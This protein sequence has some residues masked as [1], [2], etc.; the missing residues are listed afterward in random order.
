MT[1]MV[2]FSHFLVYLAV[3]FLL[4]V[5]LNGLSYTYGSERKARLSDALNLEEGQ[6]EIQKCAWLWNKVPW[7]LC[8]LAASLLCLD[9]ISWCQVIASHSLASCTFFQNSVIAQEEKEIRS[10]DF[11]YLFR[12]GH[13]FFMVIT[14]CILFRF[15]W[16]W[17]SVSLSMHDTWYFYLPDSSVPALKAAM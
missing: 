13:L 12:L 11:F 3:F 1:I 14:W 10:Q 7:E 4:D 2:N 15:F 6:V 16:T 8:P 9:S 17:I 5:C